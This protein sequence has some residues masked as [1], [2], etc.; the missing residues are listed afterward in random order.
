LKYLRFSHESIDSNKIRL[1]VKSHKIWIKVQRVYVSSKYI[2][3]SEKRHKFS[4]KWMKVQRVYVSPKRTKMKTDI[5]T[6]L[7]NT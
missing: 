2:V 1:G 4:R 3:E 7:S 5:D 6:K